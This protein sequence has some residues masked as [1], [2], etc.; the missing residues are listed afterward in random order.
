MMEITAMHLIGIIGTILASTSFAI[1]SARNVKSADGFS[2]AGRAA[3]APMVAG[4]IAGV[5]IGGGATV[6]TAQLAFQVGLAGWAYALG[7]GLAFFIQGLFYARPL[8]R[9][10][11]ET[12]PQFFELHYGK[13]AATAVNF[14]ATLSMLISQV[15]GTIAAVQIIILVLGAPPLYSACIFTALVIATVFFST[16]RK[17]YYRYCKN[18]YPMGRFDCW[19]RYGYFIAAVHA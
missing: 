10:G 6:G 1:Y 11:L 15:P 3:S 13:G 5:I 17:Q 7:A 18:V 8:R 2:L 4:S 9:T 16:E 12:V 19:R 14:C